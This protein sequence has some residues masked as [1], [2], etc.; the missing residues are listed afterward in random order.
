MIAEN[1]FVF[2]NFNQPTTYQQRRSQINPAPITALSA[3]SGKSI[4]KRR[5]NAGLVRQW[6]CT[7]PQ[8]K[9]GRGR[10]RNARNPGAKEQRSGENAPPPSAAIS[11]ICNKD[12]ACISNC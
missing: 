12:R 9:E 11:Q 1:T 2:L 8:R 5:S 3:E 7:H 4:L 6:G 10:A